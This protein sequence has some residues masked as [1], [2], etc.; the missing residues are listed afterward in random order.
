MS[1]D[2]FKYENVCIKASCSGEAA[3]KLGKHYGRLE[4]LRIGRSVG[5]SK[6]QHTLDGD[7]RS[8]HHGKTAYDT[9]VSDGA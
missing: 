5:A 4:K 2:R 3:D 9:D 6:Q 8:R 7:T 1:K